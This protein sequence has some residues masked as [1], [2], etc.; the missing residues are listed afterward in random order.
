MSFSLRLFGAAVLE[1]PS[2]PLSGPTLQRRRIALLAMLA[3]S[4][5]GGMS[6]DKLISH[7]WP[8]RDT[9]R[10]RHLLSALVYETRQALGEDV[11]AAA[12]DDLRLGSGITS[13]VGDFG[14]ALR[15]QRL[16]R[17]VSLYAGPF[18][19][20]FFIK[21]GAEFERWV[22]ERRSHFHR[23]TVTAAWALATQAEHSGE[24]ATA[25]HWARR[26]VALSREEPMLRRLIALLDRL[27]DR[28]GA[29]R[30]YEEFARWLRVECE[31]VPSAETR[32]LVDAV[33]ARAGRA[34]TPARPPVRHA[35][36]AMPNDDPV[37][38][39][40][41]VAVLPFAIFGQGDYAYLG[42]G[43][44]DLLSTSIDGAGRL[45]SVD[46]RSLLGYLEREPL[47][48][49]DPERGRSVARRF[50]AGLYV[51]GSV[52]AVGTRLQISA[53][54]YDATGT[55][56]STAQ[57]SAGEE[58]VFDAVDD[59]ARRLLLTQLGGPAARLRR[60]AVLTTHS[61]PAL[62]AFLAGESAYRLGRAAMD[63]Y[64][65]AV[66]LDP[67]FALAHYRLAVA[68]T[69]NFQPELARASATEALRHGERL[70]ERDRRLL[71]AF[72]AYVRGDSA[73][74]ERLY[75]AIVA[76][77][78]DELE[79]WYQLGEVRFHY[80]PLGGA[81]IAE[82]R[83]AFERALALDP[84]HGESLIHLTVVAV[85]ERR[86]DDART[87]FERVQ[88][89]GEL[90]VQVRTLGAFVIGDAAE[91]DRAAEEI[92][93]A[94]DAMLAMAVRYV[95]AS[96]PDRA[97]ADRLS[98][99]LVAPE[100]SPEARALGRV[101][102]AQFALAHGR[103]ADAMRE[104]AAIPSAEPEWELEYRALFAL[105]PFAPTSVEALRALQG[106]LRRMTVRSSVPRLNPA[107]N[108]LFTI[109]DNLHATLRTYLL[110]LVSAHVGDRDGALHCAVE[111]DAT[112]GAAEPRQLAGAMAA[113][114]RA[115]VTLLAEG[116]D[117]GGGPEGS[118][119]AARAF[120]MLE[121]ARPELPW[122][123]AYFSPFYARALERYRCA[124]LLFTVGRCED[125]L[126]WYESL[127]DYTPHTLPYVAPAHLRQGEI[128]E[129]L[130]RHAD[131]ITHYARFAELWQ[132]AD[133][134]LRPAV[135]R[136]RARIA[137]LRVESRAG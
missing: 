63:A 54:L 126:R 16:E 118:D 62:K 110:G 79:A 74:A 76:V 69:T 19:D 109:H 90:P 73:T 56:R 101:L 21:D 102:R 41:R 86:Y 65:L 120:A 112:M 121:Q 39:P 129:S 28:A 91:R 97:A 18:L 71:E 70:S 3:A 44:V 137:S 108:T 111:L 46:A 117:P 136:A 68:A 67:T 122:E 127:A 32:E 80:G 12:G 11:V 88:L 53:S 17:A 34:A 36:P 13:D 51:L 6:R 5:R 133:V 47:E 92:A 124:E 96:T 95:A 35:P 81:P 116:D 2:G 30:A 15:E 132:D 123:L 125:A 43:I 40:D 99:L 50:G 10:A 57:T 113:S 45:R 31:L 135:A 128:F 85:I 107:P 42:E 25:A 104:L 24:A 48:P 49:G 55:L 9:T 106:D 98:R 52:V 64:R 103:L 7:L 93:G 1:G 78:P 59:L 105:L 75:R 72:D 27:G 37:G 61:L 131:A 60:L 89:T 77:D 66:T 14:D 94:S 84:V 58:A 83:Y 38:S 22:D 119:T 4:G 114:V 130:G 8:E 115:A 33:R 100:R 23:E 87:L 82:S 134:E 29:V 26:A 20:G